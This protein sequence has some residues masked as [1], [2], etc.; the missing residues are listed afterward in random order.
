MGQAKAVEAAYW[1]LIGLRSSE[2]RM[3]RPACSLLTRWQRSELGNICQD[4]LCPASTAKALAHT[5]VLGASMI[6]LGGE[7]S[8]LVP[9]TNVAAKVRKED[10]MK[11][12]KGSKVIWTQGIYLFTAWS[13]PYKMIVIW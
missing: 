13:F 4:S 12:A 3:L 2:G 1:M 9:R 5:A 11:H 8:V 10:N 6:E 7:H